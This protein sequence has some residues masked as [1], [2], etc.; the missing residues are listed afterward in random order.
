MIKAWLHKLL[1]IKKRHLELSEEEHEALLA[2]ATRA[3]ERLKRQIDRRIE[4]MRA[5]DTLRG[6]RGQH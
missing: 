5:E 4:L 1:R 2:Q 6:R 3:R